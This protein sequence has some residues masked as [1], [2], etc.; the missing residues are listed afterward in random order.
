MSIGRVF[1]NE[2]A[3]VSIKRLP[4]FTV[5]FILGVSSISFTDLSFLLGQYR[6]SNFCVYS[7]VSPCKDLKVRAKSLN[8][9]RFTTGSQCNCL[10][11]GVMCARGGGLHTTRAAALC[12]N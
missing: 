5:L 11:I 4:Y 2:A 7:G 1:H 9:H 6:F 3:E 8:W 12:A 10:M